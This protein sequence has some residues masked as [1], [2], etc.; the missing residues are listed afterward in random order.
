[1]KTG[2]PG[3]YEGYTVDVLD[4]LAEANNFT[5]SIT[6]EQD[7]VYGV[8]D[9]KGNWNGMMGQLVSKK[10]DLAAA[11]LTVTDARKMDVSFTSPVFHSSNRILVWRPQ[12][13]PHNGLVVLFQP[14]SGDVWVMLMVVCMIVGILLAIINRYSPSEWSKI[15]EPED[16]TNS[17]DSFTVNNALFFVHTTVCWQGFKEAPRSPGGRFLTSM[18]MSFVLFMITAYIAN[19]ASFLIARTPDKP[20]LPF[21]TFHQMELQSDVAYGT[22]SWDNFLQRSNDPVLN[23]LHFISRSDPDNLFETDEEGFERVKSYQGKFAA[24]MEGHVA[25]YFAGR[26]CSVMV[27][28]ERVDPT[29]QAIGCSDETLCSE[30]SSSMNKVPLKDLRQKWWPN[31]C[32]SEPLSEFLNKPEVTLLTPARPL[33]TIDLSIAFILLLLGII[34]GVI[35]LL[36][37]VYLARKKAKKEGPIKLKTTNGDNALTEGTEEE[38]APIAEEC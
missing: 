3:Q 20:I 30:L 21:K 10:A 37:E 16:K 11:D 28:G 34:V 17:R 19:L 26:D 8:K 12:V 4:A 33:N 31:N 7:G 2:S 29:E 32:N 18:W 24:I 9:D 23:R 22:K 1:M 14:F 35:M 27:V 36:V 15:P 5:Y 6:P 13:P 25:D 38:K